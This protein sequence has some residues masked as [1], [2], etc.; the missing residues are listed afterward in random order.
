MRNNLLSGC[1]TK[2]YKNT[3]TWLYACRPEHSIEAVT[4]LSTITLQGDPHARETT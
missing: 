1:M 3:A 2:Q 4:H